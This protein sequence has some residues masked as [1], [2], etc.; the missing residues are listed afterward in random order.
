MDSG[1]YIYPHL[2]SSVGHGASGNTIMGQMLMMA[3]GISFI[4]STIHNII[5][6]VTLLCIEEEALGPLTCVKLHCAPTI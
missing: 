1:E 3:L 6:S 2:Q 5:R 4:A